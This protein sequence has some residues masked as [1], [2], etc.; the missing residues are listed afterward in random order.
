[1]A[2]GEV[3]RRLIAKI[4][5]G[6]HSTI[7][8]SALSPPQMGVGVKGASEAI[9]RRLQRVLQAKSK[10]CKLQIDVSS[11]FNTVDWNA[12]LQRVQALIPPLVR[13]QNNA[14]LRA[15]YPARRSPRT[16]PILADHSA[17]AGGSDLP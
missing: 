9:A 10:L 3:L 12:V 2:V 17:G 13:R 1:M 4:L 14:V 16:S 8:V 15:R 11:A 7:L 6:V 5:L